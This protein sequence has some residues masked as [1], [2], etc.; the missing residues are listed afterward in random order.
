LSEHNTLTLST[1][2]D[3]SIWAASV[4]YVND[5]F[6]LYF[7]SDPK[8]RHGRNILDNPSVAATIDEGSFDWRKIKGIQLEGRAVPALGLRE[9][10]RVWSLYLKKFPFVSD[11]FSAASAPSL[12]VFAKATST[13]FFKITPSRILFLEN[14]R[15]FGHREELRLL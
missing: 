5:R 4:F 11:F 12:S 8:T 1:C 10:A 14:E 15:G 6:D 7:L 13:Q 2:A 9:K 3:S